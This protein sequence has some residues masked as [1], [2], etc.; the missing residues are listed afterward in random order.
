VYA[1]LG[2]DDEGEQASRTA[3]E[4]SEGLPDFERY[5]IRASHAMILNDHEQAIASYERLAAEAPADPQINF[6][7]ADLYERTGDLDKARERLENVLRNDPN[8]VDALYALGRVSIR[9][10]QPQEALEPLNR[11]LSLAVQA[12]NEDGRGRVLHAIGIA[13]KNL[14]R[15]KEALGNYR[16]SLEI[17]RALDQK[18]GVAASL[19]EIANVQLAL[20]DFDEARSSLATALVIARPATDGPRPCA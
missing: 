6:N 18:S 19:S 1:D 13:Y 10:G 15:L 4:L 12:G 9:S 14:G 16:D 7:L 5:L 20:G 3:L 2:R 11:A 8:Y 17:R